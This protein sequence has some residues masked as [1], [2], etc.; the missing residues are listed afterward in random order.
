MIRIEKEEDKFMD[1]HWYYSVTK[2]SISI[3]KAK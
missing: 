3:G 1:V 2:K